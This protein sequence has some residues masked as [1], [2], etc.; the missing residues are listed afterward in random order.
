[1]S[2]NWKT[3]NPTFLANF[4]RTKYSVLLENLLR[5]I[6]RAVYESRREPVEFQSESRARR[7]E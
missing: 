4:A 6:A 7:C 5:K 3:K 2:K 1:M